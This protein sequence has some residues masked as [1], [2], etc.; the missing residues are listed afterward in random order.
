MYLSYSG[1]KKFCECPRCYY[2]SYVA[3]TP[4]P[5]PDNRVGMLYGQTVGVLFEAFYNEKL[6]KLP[7]PEAAMVARSSSVLKSVMAKEAAAGG[8]FDWK[9]SSKTDYKC[10]ADIL[11]DVVDTI[12]RGL[13]AIRQ[14]RLLSVDAIAEDKLDTNIG[15]NRFGG[16]ADF[17]M[18]R[19][20]PYEDRVIVDGKG[21][22]HRDKYTDVKQLHWYSLLHQKKYGSLPD[23]VAFIFWRDPPETAVDWHTV[24][25]KD[26]T[27][28]RDTVLDTM[29][30]IDNMSKKR[31]PL[32]EPTSF[33]AK[34]SSSGC[35][36]CSYNTICPE[37]IVMTSK[38]RPSYS[39]DE[40]VEDV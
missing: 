28:L 32:S 8:V 34:P 37:G 39:S 20:A 35:R 38:D 12:P 36:L 22:R 13:E 30:N 3:K 21:S 11:K 14:H 40:G 29:S 23:K 6:W 24:S 27:Q 1:F 18:R 33:P 9:E 4:L 25:E 15:G 2:Y 16:R 31:L 5:K 17:V 19:P 26:V 10:Q 7:D